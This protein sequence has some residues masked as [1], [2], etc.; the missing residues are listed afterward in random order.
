MSLTIFYT[1]AGLQAEA[2]SLQIS[3]CNTKVYFIHSFTL[4][5]ICSPTLQQLL[6]HTFS[7]CQHRL[8]CSS[9]KYHEKS[10]ISTHVRRATLFTTDLVAAIFENQLRG[11]GDAHTF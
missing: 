11:C 10:N 5:F 3:I 7:Q 4:S 6:S 8:Y 1:S 2:V 9:H